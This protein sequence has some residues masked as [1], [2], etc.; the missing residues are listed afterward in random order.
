MP[1]SSGAA[2]AITVAAVGTRPLIACPNAHRPKPDPNAAN[3]RP[4]NRNNAT[5]EKE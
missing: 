1:V 4:A 5:G 3:A 2:A